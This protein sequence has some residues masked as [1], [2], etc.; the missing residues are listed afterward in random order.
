MSY[1]LIDSIFYPINKSWLIFKSCWINILFYNYNFFIEIAKLDFISRFPLIYY[2]HKEMIVFCKN[3][4]N[5]SS[6]WLRV[7][8]PFSTRVSLSIKSWR[9]IYSF[10]A[11]CQ[12]FYFEERSELAALC[13][14][15]LLGCKV[16]CRQHTSAEGRPL[17]F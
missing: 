4:W 17:F 3:L 11:K 15:L 14:C 2:C 6:V 5:S 8:L 9:R 1:N 16:V 12:W 13:L 7:V 10:P